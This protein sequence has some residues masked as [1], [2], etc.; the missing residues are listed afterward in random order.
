MATSVILCKPRPEHLSL[1]QVVASVLDELQLMW[2]RDVVLKSQ[3]FQ[4]H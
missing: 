2:E 4:Q 3:A 1:R